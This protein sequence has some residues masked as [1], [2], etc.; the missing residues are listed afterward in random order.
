MW[1]PTKN[2]KQKLHCSIMSSILSEIYVCIYPDDGLFSPK[3][4]VFL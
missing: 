2:R 3:H 1:D 4:V